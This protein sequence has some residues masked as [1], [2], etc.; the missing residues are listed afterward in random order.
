MEVEG[1]TGKDQSKNNLPF[2]FRSTS[3]GSDSSRGAEN[4]HAHT[5]PS[6]EMQNT[7]YWTTPLNAA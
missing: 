4:D 7:I 5:H 6:S 3:N 1:L 2:V